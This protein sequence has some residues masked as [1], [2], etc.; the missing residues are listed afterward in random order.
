MGDNG[1]RTDHQRPDCREGDPGQ[2][3]QYRQTRSDILNGAGVNGGNSVVPGRQSREKFTNLDSADFTQHQRIGAHSKRLSHK[4]TERDRS[5]AFGIR[6]STGQMDTVRMN[7]MEFGD[8][9]D[10]D[11]P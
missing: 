9:L 5:S 4:L 8:V 3:T 1:N 6:R 10:D 11:N 7:R 2:Q